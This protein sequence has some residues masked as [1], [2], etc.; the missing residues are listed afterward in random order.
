MYLVKMHNEYQSIN[1][2][3]YHIWEKLLQYSE[4][5]PP[6]LWQELKKI[7]GE[8][9][10]SKM[11]QLIAD[12]MQL[13]INNGQAPVSVHSWYWDRYFLSFSPIQILEV[14]AQFRYLI[15]VSGKPYYVAS[16]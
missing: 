9:V 2:H 16:R 14:L 11:I 10:N 4:Q 5:I 7:A 6:Y 12:A 15:P 1:I 3:Y 13:S 8:S